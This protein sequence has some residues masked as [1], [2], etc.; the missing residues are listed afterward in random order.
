MTIS[1]KS[2]PFRPESDRKNSRTKRT[3][4][5]V[6][7]TP[8]NNGSLGKSLFS[9]SA[10][11][12]D[13]QFQCQAHRLRA[14]ALPSSSARSVATMAI[15]DKEYTKY[16]P[17]RKYRRYFGYCFSHRKKSR[18]IWVARDVEVTAPILTAKSCSTTYHIDV[19]ET[20]EANADDQA[21]RLRRGLRPRRQ[22]AACTHTPLLLVDRWPNFQDRYMPPRLPDQVRRIEGVY[23]SISA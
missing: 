21:H 16:R 20:E 14:M 7:N 10:F 22:R 17:K 11:R 5:A 4:E 13:K 23:E 9:L 12:F 19:S 1:K 6:T 18:R 8:A 2:I 15:S 3:S